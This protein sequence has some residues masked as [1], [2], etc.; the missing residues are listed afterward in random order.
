MVK[1]EVLKKRLEQL[2][3]S[4]NKIKRYQKLSLE[5]FLEDDIV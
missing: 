4:L 1:I 5:E 2:N 3:L